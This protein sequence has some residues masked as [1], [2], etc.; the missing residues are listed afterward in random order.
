MKKNKTANILAIIILFCIVA[1]LIILT[2][3]F[4]ILN[5]I[6]DN[7]PDLTGNTAGNLNN[8][9]F[10]CEDLS[11]GTVYFANPYDHGYLYSMKGNQTELKKLYNSS[12]SNIAVGG[13]Y[14]YFSMETP[15]G[16][17]GLGFV[18]KTSGIYRSTKKGTKVTNLTSDTS[19]TMNLIG[20]TI[21]YQA[22]TGSGV[23]LKKVDI[24]GDEEPVI[25][26][27]SFVLNP[28]CAVDGKIYYGGT[29]QDHYLYSFDP[30]TETA[31]ALWDGDVWNP[32]WADGYFYYMDISDNYKICR[33]SPSTQTVDK[34]TDDRADNF[35][36][37]Y[38]YVFYSVSVGDA[39][40]LYRMRMDGSDRQQ[41]ATGYVRDINITSDYVYFR[42]FGADTPVYCFPTM[43]GSGV[44]EFT[45]AFNAAGEK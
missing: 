11:S 41:I 12:C 40:G 22:G 18:I 45:A 3:I 23:G 29:L 33:Y 2:V 39:P 8:G 10:F 35:N 30:I 32:V 37:G 19:L 27:D 36:V 16:G 14:L 25:I 24:R 9:G 31:S 21:Y 1:M 5:R 38:G 13:D 43:G 26:Q 28:A 44:T 6:P 4:N 17:S 34:L 15:E 20:S 7:P 42:S